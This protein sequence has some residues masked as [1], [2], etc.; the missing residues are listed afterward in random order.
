MPELLE[1]CEIVTVHLPKS[2]R[3]IGKEEFQKLGAHK[4][5]I[6]TSL[7]MPFDEVAFQHW[8][9]KEG[10]FAIFDGDAQ[11][12]LSAKTKKIKNFIE[13]PCQNGCQK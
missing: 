2:N 12:E 11:N 1:K 9:Q 6:N 7:G 5:F 4:V 8:L 13:N 3:L 10:N